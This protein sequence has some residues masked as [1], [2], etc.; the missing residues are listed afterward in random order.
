MSKLA[1]YLK[2]KYKKN[3]LTRLEIAM[4][5]QMSPMVVKHMLKDKRLKSQKVEDVAKAIEEHF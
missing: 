1:L 5:M 4:E 3:I 2:R